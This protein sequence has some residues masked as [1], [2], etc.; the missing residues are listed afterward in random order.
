MTIEQNKTFSFAANR[1]R[2]AAKQLSE[3][4]HKAANDVLAS[5]RF[6]STTKAVEYLIS[7]GWSDSQIAQKIRY[8]TDT[9][10]ANGRGHRKGDA[11]RVQHVNN[12]RAKYTAKK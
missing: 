8:E 2:T 12:I 11:L 4:D 3:D 6:A 7:L 9:M 10:D 1:S 5:G